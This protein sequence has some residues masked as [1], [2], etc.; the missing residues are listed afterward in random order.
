MKEYK[1]TDQIIKASEELLQQTLQL[2]GNEVA[3]ALN[4][5]H[6]HV[7]SHRNYENEQALASAIYLA[8][9]DALNYYTVF[10]ETSAG[11]GTADLIY[12]PLHPD[13]KYPPMIIELK[14]N[15]T[16][17]RA[18]QQ[19]KSKEYFHAFDHYNGKILFVGINYD[20]KKKHQCVIEEV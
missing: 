10:K 5:S 15:K 17:G 3:K 18:I 14:S 19:I 8:F 2:N 16:P 1:V 20:E 7:A 12:T 11:N 4:R 13:G 6:I 9:I